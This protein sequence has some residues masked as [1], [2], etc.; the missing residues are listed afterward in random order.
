MLTDVCYVLGGIP[1]VGTI[2]SRIP[3]VLK[4][5]NA[6]IKVINQLAKDYKPVLESVKN[7]TKSL[8]KEYAL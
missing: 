4:P 6:P 3:S 1:I 7:S 2:A 5:I 8:S